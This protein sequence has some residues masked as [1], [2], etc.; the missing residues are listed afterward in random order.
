VATQSTSGASVT[1]HWPSKF[2]ARFWSHGLLAYQATLIMFVLGLVR[3]IRNLLLALG[4]VVGALGV[5]WLIGLGFHFQP[6]WQLFG[7]IPIAIVLIGAA[8]ALLGYPRRTDFYDRYAPGSESKVLL[9]DGILSFSFNS[10]IIRTNVSDVTRVSRFGELTAIEF[11][12]GRC[13]IVPTAFVPHRIGEGSGREV[14]KR[15]S[16]P[17]A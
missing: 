9:A 6:Y 8:S 13:V 16:R 5:G 4:L 10:Q 14:N 7:A 15:W 11:T 1:T 17:K 12:S 2:R 3:S